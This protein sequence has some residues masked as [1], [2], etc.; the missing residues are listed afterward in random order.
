MNKAFYPDSDIEAL[1][2]YEHL[3]AYCDTVLGQP[4][5]GRYVCAFCGHSRPKMEVRQKDSRGC[6]VCVASG[7]CGDVFMV[8]QALRPDLSF[9]DAVEH[10]A[11]V[12][13]YRLTPQSEGKQGFQRKHKPT[14]P[15]DDKPRVPL[16]KQALEAQ[17]VEFLNPDMQRRAVEAVKRAIAHPIEMMR[18]AVLLGLPLEALSSHLMRESAPLGML[19][20]DERMRLCYLYLAKDEQGKYKAVGFKVRSRPQDIQTGAQR[21]YMYGKKS[22]LWGAPMLGIDL[23]LARVRLVILTEGESDA[24]AVRQALY[25]WLEDMRH[26]AP[27]DYPP[28]ELHPLILARPDAGTF[29]PEWAA[30]LKGL[31]VILTVDNDATGEKSAEALAWKLY[32]AGVN[33]VWAWHAPDGCKD[34]KDAFNKEKPHELFINISTN[35]QKINRIATV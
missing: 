25:C 12:V 8:A 19:G 29:K 17:A 4:S 2:S 3:K 27:D 15:P 20:L 14:S 16:M 31:D 24:L 26:N 1:K 32:D 34:P 7:T 10:V 18:H 23:D 35:K 28:P 11:Q 13:G 22:M 30:S 5:K 9:V 21:F 33:K 6:A